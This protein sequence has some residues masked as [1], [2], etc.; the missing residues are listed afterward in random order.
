MMRVDQNLGRDMS[1]LLP[2][3]FAGLQF[4]NTY[5]RLPSSFFSRIDPTPVQNPSLIK[6]NHALA[7]EL[8]LDASMLES[9]QAAQMFAGNAIPV[10]AEPIAQ[11]YSGHQF[12]YLNPRLGDGRA[13]LLGEV[14][15]RSGQRRDL[16]LKGPGRTPY[17]RSGDGRAALGPVLREYLVSEAMYYLG[18]KTTRALAAVTTG[19]PVYREAALPGAVLTRVAASHIRV[20]TFEYFRVRND[21]EG[22]K[23]LA[24]H[25]IARHYP[26]V[27]SAENPYL[28]LL[29][30]VMHAQASLVASWLH[31]GFIHGVMNTDNMTVSGETIDYG[32][33]AFMD[34]YDPATV[35]SSIDREGR[36][37]YG[38]QGPMAL[39]NLTRFAECL[40]PIL[41]QD[42]DRAVEKAE[43]ALGDFSD[44]FNDYWL[45]GMR[46]KIGL[47]RVLPDDENLVAEFLQIMRD[48]RADFTLAFRGLA[49]CVQSTVVPADFRGLFS[50]CENLLDPWMQKWR[51]RLAEETSDIGRIAELMRSVNPLYI[52]RNQNVENVL[53]AAVEEGDYAPFEEMLQVLRYPFVDQA[54][55]EKYATPPETPDPFYRTFCGT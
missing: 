3:G 50:S 16:Q 12:G 33:C 39:W 28:G 6:V 17:S 31:V 2:A 29:E 54:G 13:I 48:G 14:I 22:L 4:D 21:S 41:D 52:P 40:L 44:L 35:F 43:T 5:A 19:Q 18:I 55:M 7:E 8:G 11:A 42:I 45:A 37:A 10:G 30:V 24:D 9:A 23:I 53:R 15:D 47:T 1:I 34:V 32:P 27:A 51:A 49:D 20:G 25:V 38:N 46:K 36:Y 26:A